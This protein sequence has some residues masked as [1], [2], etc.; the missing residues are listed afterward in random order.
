MK[1]N[2]R[3]LHLFYHICNSRRRYRP[4][5]HSPL[6]SSMLYI[7]QLNFELSRIASHCLRQA[8]KHGREH[9]TSK[10]TSS[11]S[12]PQ[13]NYKL[14]HGN[15]GGVGNTEAPLGGG[16]LNI[17]YPCICLTKYLVSHKFRSQISRKLKYRPFFICY[18][19]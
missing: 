17:P 10:R 15:S 7:H 1:D 3:Q 14:I 8:T 5:T 13:E 6:L 19:L 9:I 12:S 2:S 11:T 16:G 4:G 18:L